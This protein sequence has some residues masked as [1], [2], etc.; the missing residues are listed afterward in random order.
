MKSRITSQNRRRRGL[1]VERLEDRRLLA[2]DWQN[3]RN[4][5]DVDD[6]GIVSPLDALLVINDLDEAGSRMLPAIVTGAAPDYYLDVNGDD[7]TSPLDPLIVINA[8]EE[9]LQPLA[10]APSFRIKT[11]TSAISSV[12]AMSRSPS[13]SPS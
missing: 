7:W 2:G 10:I 9:N 13:L 4:A 5:L 11:T 1:F 12:S 8:I 6:S 3:P